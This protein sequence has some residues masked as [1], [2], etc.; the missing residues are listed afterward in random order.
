MKGISKIVGVM[1][2][3]R[4]RKARTNSTK[5]PENLRKTCTAFC[6]NRARTLRA[7]QMQEELGNGIIPFGTSSVRVGKGPVPVQQHLGRQASG[8]RTTRP[9]ARLLWSKPRVAARSL[10]W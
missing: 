5:S 6:Y 7:W 4:S 8:R 1:A 3:E 2:L 9:D 10:F